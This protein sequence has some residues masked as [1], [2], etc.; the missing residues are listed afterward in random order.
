MEFYLCCAFLDSIPMTSQGKVTT[1][2]EFPKWTRKRNYKTF[3]IQFKLDGISIELQYENG[4]F[5]HAVTR[6]DGTIGDNVSAN[7][8]KMKGFISKLKKKI[9]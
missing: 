8:I 6:R 3:L 7:V 1:P 2:A 4:L 9:S 5:Q